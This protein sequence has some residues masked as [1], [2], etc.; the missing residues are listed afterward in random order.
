MLNHVSPFKL[1]HCL[2]WGKIFS[3][4][5]TW[6][7]TRLL[8]AQRTSFET[9]T[10]C[11]C[12]TKTLQLT[13]EEITWRFGKRTRW[14]SSQPSTNWMNLKSSFRACAWTCIQS[15]RIFQWVVLYLLVTSCTPGIYTNI[16]TFV[17]WRV[18]SPGW[19]SF[20][21]RMMASDT[22]SLCITQW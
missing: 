22:L 2:Q 18:R 19:D 5:L 3:D 12:F 13:D 6:I 9:S 7:E 11:N 16:N 17:F 10:M 1:L 15:S 21:F 20:A 14:S 4:L 8:L